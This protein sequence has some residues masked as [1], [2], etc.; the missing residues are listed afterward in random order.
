MGRHGASLDFDLLTTPERAPGDGKTGSVTN[1]Y[2]HGR[3]PICRHG[4]LVED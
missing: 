2:L 4:E 1:I 3:H